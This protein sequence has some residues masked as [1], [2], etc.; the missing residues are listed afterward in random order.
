MKNLN[1][2]KPNPANYERF[3]QASLTLPNEALSITDILN[4]WTHGID[5]MLTKNPAYSDE[6]DIDDIDLESVQRMDITDKGEAM[7]KA[8]NVINRAKEAQKREKEE[9]DKKKEK[10]GGEEEK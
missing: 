9:A 3:E 5:P 7:Q 8:S 4:K 1:G 6:A 10:K 2:Y